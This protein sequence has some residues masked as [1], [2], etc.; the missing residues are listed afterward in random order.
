M[1]RN[2]RGRDLR[3]G[4]GPGLATFPRVGQGSQRSRRSRA[5]K[6]G[7]GALGGG[8]CYKEAGAARAV[9]RAR[10]PRTMLSAQERD[11]ILRVWDLIAGHEAPFGAELLLRWAGAGSPGSQGGG[12]R[13]VAPE[14]AGGRTKGG[15]RG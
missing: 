11:Q 2:P 3:F 5:D 6:D 12:D 1:A 7:R 8:G 15:F 10:H 14:S 13:G 4:S 9:P